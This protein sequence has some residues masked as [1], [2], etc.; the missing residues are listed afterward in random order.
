MVQCAEYAQR[1]GRAVTLRLIR[2]VPEAQIRDAEV[3]EQAP[4]L[5]FDPRVE[6]ERALAL[7]VPI[8]RATVY[9]MLGPRLSR[10]DVVQDALIEV[11]RALDRFEGRAS[12]TTYARTIT[13]RVV[14]R[15]LSRARATDL[16]MCE[17]EHV[18]TDP[19]PEAELVQRQA[20][21]RLHRCLRR[22][23]ENRRTAFI[24]CGLE[25]M[26]PHA[27]AELTGVS[28]GAMRARYMHARR[29]LARMLGLK[30][31]DEDHAS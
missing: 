4:T 30:L 31:K 17:D 20:L 7:V 15:A 22:L 25:E 8:V 3:E 24:L 27:A 2:K 21:A 12:L 13:V 19:T 16:T 10:D 1:R 29:E 11:A 28:P 18:A 9:R 6:K 14:Y 26:S 5:T 23:P